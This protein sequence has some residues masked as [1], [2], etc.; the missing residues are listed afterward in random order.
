MYQSQWSSN[1]TVHVDW[2]S[3]MGLDASKLGGGESEDA[4][5]SK[6]RTCKAEVESPSSHFG[7]LFLTQNWQRL[8]YN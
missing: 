4:Y 7:I 8:A 1:P 2:K 6:K 3:G 5:D